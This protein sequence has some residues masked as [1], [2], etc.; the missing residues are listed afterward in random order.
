MSPTFLQF[1]TVSLGSC[2]M[3]QLHGIEQKFEQNQ[4]EENK[5]NPYLCL[6][7]SISYARLC[8]KEQ[9]YAHLAY[10]SQMQKQIASS[11]QNASIFV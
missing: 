11:K 8:I 9:T 7:I 1:P 5:Q 3:L 10:T 4:V 2:F 6:Y